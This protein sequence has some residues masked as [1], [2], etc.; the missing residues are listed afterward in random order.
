MTG[1]SPTDW[2][3]RRTRASTISFS[4]VAASSST[5]TS[6][7]DSPPDGYTVTPTFDQEN[8]H[9]ADRASGM[10]ELVFHRLFFP[11]MDRW[12]ETVGVKDGDYQSTF[13][14]HADR[15]LR[16]TDAMRTH[17]GLQR[18]DRFAVMAC[19]SH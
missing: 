18:D 13:A 7:S 6:S 12:A 15:V 5:S 11:A 16:L 3:P 10:K 2:V 17:L 8:R 1:H 14:T 9:G 19:N 4:V